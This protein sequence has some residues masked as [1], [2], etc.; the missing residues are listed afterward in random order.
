M[1]EI[2][3]VENIVAKKVLLNNVNILKTH[4]PACC[5][6]FLS[7]KSRL[8]SLWVLW[9]NW[10]ND[11]FEVT[12]RHSFH[13]WIAIFLT[14]IVRGSWVWWVY[15][16]VSISQFTCSTRYWINWQSKIIINCCGKGAKKSCNLYVSFTTQPHGNSWCNFIENVDSLREKTQRSC[17]ITYVPLAGYVLTAR[18]WGTGGCGQA[19][20]EGRRKQIHSHRP[21]SELSWVCLMEALCDC[22]LHK[23]HIHNWNNV[24]CLKAWRGPPYSHGGTGKK[25]FISD[26]RLRDSGT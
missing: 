25:G 9:P 6:N 4:P 22:I 17:L 20:R 24:N 10:N 14:W 2:K 23:R 8:G 15:P 5:A 16:S 19:G 18:P 26:M 13:S 3:G 11:R 1:I 7:S 12:T 21:L